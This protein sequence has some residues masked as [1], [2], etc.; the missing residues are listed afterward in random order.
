MGPWWL[1]WH[2]CLYICEKC[3]MSRLWHTNTRTHE[4]W[5]V[6]QYSVWAES[7][8]F[9]NIYKN[10]L[11]NRH[12]PHNLEVATCLALPDKEEQVVTIDCC[13][14]LI[15]QED[16]FTGE[17]PMF[18][19]W[20]WAK[21]WKGSDLKALICHLEEEMPNKEVGPVCCVVGDGESWVLAEA[22]QLFPVFETYQMSGKI[23][24]GQLASV[25]TWSHQG[26]AQGARGSCPRPS[27]P[28]SAPAAA[29]C[30]GRSQTSAAWRS[31]L[32]LE[33]YMV[34]SS[35]CRLDTS[36]VIFSS[37]GLNF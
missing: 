5:K 18:V 35:S 14:C 20:G 11:I 32:G 24:V 31:L 1:T 33:D 25:G 12:L 21:V 37:S 4:Q 34:K 23:G 36:K 7:A 27:R 17:C 28:T 10:Y 3:E 9:K 2:L 13:V 19:K 6:E 8:I 29:S 16:T 22:S 30:A 15:D 26:A